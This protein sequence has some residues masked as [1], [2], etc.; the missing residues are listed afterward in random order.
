MDVEER[1][2]NL[3][4]DRVFRNSVLLV[5]GI[6][7]DSASKLKI[8]YKSDILEKNAKNWK[9]N[10]LNVDHNSSVLSRIGFIESPKWENNALMA[11]LRIL[12]ITTVARDVLNLI[13]REIIN[14]LSIEALTDEYFDQNLSCLCIKNIEFLGAA[15]V[16]NPAVSD[17]KIK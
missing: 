2:S 4:G 16:T 14:S 15:V 1:S 6:F 17:S 8:F 10:F 9:S 7:Q 13:D 12:P 5:P 3:V 11:D